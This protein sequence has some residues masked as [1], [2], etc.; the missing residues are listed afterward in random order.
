MRLS[1]TASSFHG[2][3][4]SLIFIQIFLGHVI[5]RHLVGMDFLPF[6]IVGLLD[7]C[8]RFRLKGVPFFEQFIDAF[9]IRAFHVG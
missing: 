8:N 6:V 7:A 5:L 2:G 1:F 4:A 3:D 9:R